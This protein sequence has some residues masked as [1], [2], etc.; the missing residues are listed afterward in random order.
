MQQSLHWIVFGIIFVVALF[1]D[2]FV[3]QRKAHVIP[4]KEALKLD[5]F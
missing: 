4:V 3:F 1:L 5:G 2:L